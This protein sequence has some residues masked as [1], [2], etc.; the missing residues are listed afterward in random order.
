MVRMPVQSTSIASVGYDPATLLLDVEFT[1]GKV[2]RYAAVQP[3][4]YGALI[5]AESIGA[6]FGKHIRGKFHGGELIPTKEGV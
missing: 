5:A 2:Y 1:S 3:E 6:H 4:V